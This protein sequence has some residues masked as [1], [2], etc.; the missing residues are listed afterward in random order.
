[1]Q[2]LYMIVPREKRITGSKRLVYTTVTVHETGNEAPGAGALAHGRL[3]FNGNSRYASWHETVDDELCV[4]SYEDTAVCFHAGKAAGNNTSYSIEIC[5]NGKSPQERFQ[6]FVNG[7]HRAA[8]K[9][10][11]RKLGIDRL[12][13]HNAWSGKNCPLHLRRGDW[14]MDWTQFRRIVE[15]RLSVLN[16]GD[17]QPSPPPEQEEDIMASI[18]DLRQLLRT[19]IGTEIVDIRRRFTLLCGLTFGFYKIE[20]RDDIVHAQESDGSFTPITN[21]TWSKFRQSPLGAPVEVR[22]LSGPA[23]EQARGLLNGTAR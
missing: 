2:V 14:G 21:Q 6:A 12:R 9:L 17:N 10:Y 13:Q 16:H 8:Q 20:G 18:E 5:V 3:Q 23:A 7:A 4:I 19:E 11:D 1:M 15:E 22:Q